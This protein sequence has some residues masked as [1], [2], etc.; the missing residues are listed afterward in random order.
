MRFNVPQFVDIEDTI[1][2]PLTLKQ[3]FLLIASGLIFAL[4]WWA[5]QL[6]FVLLIGVP[7][8]LIIIAAIFI[9]VGGRSLPKV[10]MAWFNYWTKPRFYIWKKN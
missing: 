4:L 6:W 8:M 9:K 5:F 7:M 1:L 2:G 10:F 3:F